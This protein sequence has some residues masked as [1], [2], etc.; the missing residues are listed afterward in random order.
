MVCNGVNLDNDSWG[1]IANGREITENGVYYEDQLSM[2]EGL[3]VVVQNYGFAVVFYWLYSAFGPVGIFVIMLLFNLLLCW[4]IYKICMLISNKNENL[5]LFIMI[6][7][8]LLL[9]RWFIVTRA[10]VVS[11]C[12]IML[13][14]YLLEL[15]IKRGKSKYLWWIPLLSLFEINSHASVWPIIP[16]VLV[17]YIIDSFKSKKLHLQG[18]KTKPLL[19][20]LAGSVLVGLIN[21][22]GFKMMT[23]ILTSYSVPEAQ[24]FVSELAAFRPLGDNSGLLLYVSIVFVILLYIFGKKQNIRMRWLILLFGFLALGLNTVRGMGY[25]ILVLL[26]PL[27]AVYQDFSLSA[28]YKKWCRIAMIW[29]GIM[30]VAVTII[31]MV[32]RV[33]EMIDGPSKE[34]ISAVDKIDEFTEGKDKKSLKVYADYNF[35]GFLEYRGYKPYID[36]RMEV[37]IKVNNGKEDIFQEF[38]YLGRGKDG[39]SKQ[40]FLEKY[41]FDYL[42]V[43]DYDMLFDY[44]FESMGYA[45]IYEN[46]NEDGEATLRVFKR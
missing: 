33:P 5:S 46:K 1:V 16:I 27:A 26:F 38:Y 36:P 15:Y 43:L 22:Y 2:H 13:V 8:D 45:K 44:D 11:F 32:I 29:M 23:L 37:F 12:V 24:D 9:S 28:K 14:V 4:L 39:L 40:E 10:Q 6:L 18:Y 34:L 19:I 7:T 41:N 25:L 35:G 31:T 42:L 21:P 20:T 17:V 3:E 30:A